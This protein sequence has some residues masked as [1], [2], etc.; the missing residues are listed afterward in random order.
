MSSELKKRLILDAWICRI[1]ASSKQ[2]FGNQVKYFVDEIKNNKLYESILLLAKSRFPFEVDELEKYQE[3][4]LAR[5]PLS[6]ECEEEEAAFAYQ[7]LS[8]LIEEVGYEKLN[9]V[10]MFQGKD[11]NETHEK[12]IEQLIKPQI[13]WIENQEEK[14]GLVLYLFGKYKSRCEWFTANI[15]Y[16]NY[17]QAVSNYETPLEDDLRLFLFDQGIPYPFS[18]PRSSSGRV[19]I[20]A[21][22]MGD[23]PLIAEVKIFD[24]SKGYSLNRIQE[25]F[26]QVVKYMTDYRKSIG[27]LVIFNMDSVELQFNFNCEFVSHFPYLFF[28]KRIVYFVV[29]NCK[30]DITASKIGKLKTVEIDEKSIMFPMDG[31]N[32]P[33]NTKMPK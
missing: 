33:F 27:Y 26:T 4:I 1:I 19:D 15:L 10:V 8:Y 6:F 2:Q 20:L 23:D 11:F 3:R 22:L 31:L 14:D 30:K 13:R 29:I 25:G 9:E 24:R 12:I 5:I 28:N 17:R 16:S 21:N 32:N 18:T 7:F